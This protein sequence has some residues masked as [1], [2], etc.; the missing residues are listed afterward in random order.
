[1]RVGQLL[2]GLSS[3]RGP[4]LR[5]RAGLGPPGQLLGARIRDVIASD[6]LPEPVAYRLLREGAL[7]A[8]PLLLA[9]PWWRCQSTVHPNAA[10]FHSAWA[11]ALVGGVVAVLVVPGKKTVEA[12]GARWAERVERMAKRSTVRGVLLRQAPRVAD[13][14]HLMALSIH[15]AIPFPAG[16]GG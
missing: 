3:R 14:R 15:T 5:G 7:A 6:L 1:M 13:A 11:T 9:D 2:T 4:V 10:G 8:D 16:R 12:L